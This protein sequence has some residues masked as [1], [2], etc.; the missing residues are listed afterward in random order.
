MRHEDLSAGGTTVRINRFLGMCGVASRRKAEDLVREGKVSVNGRVV[1]DL[2][3]RIN[4]ERD[5]VFVNGKQIARVHDY[6][7]LVMNK[8]RDTITTLHDERGRTTVLSL[9]RTRDRVFPVGRLD[10]NTTGVLLFTND[11]EF[12]HRLMHPR[13]EIPKSYRVTCDKPV[14]HEHLRQLRK[15]VMLDDGQT[16]PAEVVVAPRSKGKELGVII[17]E[18]RNRQVHRM[19]ETLGYEVRKLDRVAYGPITKEGIARGGTRKLT[20]RE[21]KHLRQIAGIDVD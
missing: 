8:P 15:G 3:T 21:L 11:G 14:S 13:Y 12:A 10:R 17:R 18:G 1:T 7:Y 9:L 19:F 4:P 20:H 16:A 5:K 6:V 2:A